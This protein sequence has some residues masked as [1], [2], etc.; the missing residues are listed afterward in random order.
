MITSIPT[1]DILAYI[2]RTVKP[3]PSSLAVMALV[4]VFWSIDLSLRP[5]LLKVI[6]NEVA[7]G[8]PQNIFAELA[9]PVLLYVSMFFITTITFRLYE[10]FVNIRMIPALRKKIAAEGLEVLLHKSHYYY[11]NNFSGSLANKIN[12]LTNTI[13]QIIQ[14]IIDRFFSHNIALACC[15]IT[16]S[17]VSIWFALSMG[18]WAGMFI[19]GAL[20]L[21]K[22]LAHLADNWSELGSKITGQLVDT[23][24]NILSVRLFTGKGKE[25]KLLDE[26][27]QK[28]VEGEQK[29]E[30]AYFWMWLYYGMSF[31]VLQVFNFYFLLKGRQQGWI[32]VGDFALVLVINISIIEFLWE[33]AKDFS[34]FS[35]AWGRAHQAL[36]MLWD[37]PL[38]TDTATSKPLAI[39]RGR[40]SF[41]HV[42][43]HH[44]GVS[45]LFKNLSVTIETG[46]KVG[47]VGHSGAGKT[48]F[49]HLILRLYDVT[50]GCIT[51]DDH[52]IRDIAQ[53]SLYASIAL[54][55][56]DPSLFHRSL[57]ENI[58]YGSASPHEEAIIKA[59]QEAHAHEFITKLSEGYD[60]LVGE[61][62]V[63]LSGGQR[64]RI[65]I[66]RAILKN[67][68]ILILDEATSQL[69]S[70]TER[71]IQESLWR[72]MQGKT[73]L[74]VAHRLSTLLHMDR[75]LVF[76]R[77]K[78]TQ[79]GSHQELIVQEGLY[80]TL[81]HTQT[82]GFL[83]E[84]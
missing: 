41:E 24:S 45:S 79:D 74:V 66:A 28:A 54:I 30:W 37:T 38:M 26:T 39:T 69:D 29:L 46:Q 6:L 60:T 42:H 5:Y 14:I 72:L 61:R 19:V 12:D 57:R 84:Q 21:S 10:Y 76:D 15:I 11:Q 1:R 48:T 20:L 44:K 18:A 8:N 35:K 3:F 80:K 82:G 17:Q 67:A 25:R 16:L 27:L 50:H 31:F 22:R 64:Q 73:T 75:I 43:F 83:P 32:T 49:V 4:A 56:Q 47:L 7:V 81:W 70:V 58:G 9:V 63:K 68:P 71:H 40:I 62:G 36:R 33:L 59:A 13:P 52:N 23:L 53:E 51:I 78:I 55:P 65:A 77:G 34:Q 2:C